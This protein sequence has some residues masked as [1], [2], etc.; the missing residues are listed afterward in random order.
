MENSNYYLFQNMKEINGFKGTI[1]VG[2]RELSSEDN[3]KL[4]K[5]VTNVNE[6]IKSLSNQLLNFSSDFGVRIFTSGCYFYDLNKNIWSSDGV[7]VLKDTNNSLA[8]CQTNHLTEFAGGL[9]V[10]PS[11]IDF[12]KVWANAAFLKN[13]VI[14]ATVICVVCLYVLLA[15]PTIL[16]DKKDK[17]KIGIT[18]LDITDLQ[19][20]YL[21]EIRISTGLRNGAQTDSKVI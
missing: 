4:C 11:T 10:L 17:R 19:E 15:I 2:L 21:Y 6:T 16:F 12:G 3:Y 7:E 9:I 5:N 13:P 20:K 14:Y 8:Q 18:L 1:G